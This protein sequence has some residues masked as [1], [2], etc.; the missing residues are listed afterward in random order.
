MKSL[1][2]ILVLLISYLGFGQQIKYDEWKSEAKNNIRLLPKYG[3]V[4][5]TEAQIVADNKLI[6]DYVAQTGTRHKGSE[7][8]IK[9]GFDYLYKGDIKTAMYR[10]N[11]A[12]L[13]DPKNENVFWGFGAVYFTFKDFKNA[14]TQYEEGLVLNSHS[15]NL[16]TDKASVYMSKYQITNTLNDLNT[17][18]DLFKKSLI[19]DSKNQN[20]LFKLSASYYLKKDCGNALKYYN[21]C[22]KLGGKPITTEYTNA[23]NQL[24]KK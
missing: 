15:S 7:L 19:I 5:K 8:L 3:N 4:K 9:L 24:C 14:L 16:I 17:A 11:Q 1:L 22:L 2:S 18:I 20:T 13:L 10:F 12:W 6:A 21:Q 23:L